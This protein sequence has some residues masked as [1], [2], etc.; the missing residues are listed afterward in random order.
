MQI[1]SSPAV[2]RLLIVVVSVVAT[3]VSLG[4]NLTRYQ[5]FLLL[6]GA[7]FVPLF[8]VLLADWLQLPDRVSERRAALDDAEGDRG[9][10]LPR[11]ERG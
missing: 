9:A 8:G 2:Q 10:R 4:I 6:L 3:A 7:F 5:Q 1:V 11:A